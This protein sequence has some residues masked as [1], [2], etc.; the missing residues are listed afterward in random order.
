[1]WQIA[2]ST[3]ELLARQHAGVVTINLKVLKKSKQMLMNQKVKFISNSLKFLFM[4]IYILT[5]DSLSKEQ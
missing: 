2:R 1:M 5:G 3:A 4:K